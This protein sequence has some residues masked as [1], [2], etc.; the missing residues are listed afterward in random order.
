MSDSINNLLEDLQDYMFSDKNIEKYTKNNIYK[1]PVSV[2]P[3]RQSPVKILKRLDYFQ[4][5]H[6][7]SL[8]WC[9]YILK[10]GFGKYD[11]LGNQ[12]FVEEKKI[13]FSYVDLVRLNK[14]LLKMNKIKPLSEIEDDLANKQQI[15]L[16]TF[17]AICMIMEIN[18][19]VVDKHKYYEFIRDDSKIIN[20]IYKT[21]KP[22]KYSLD[23][24]SSQEKIDNYRKNYFKMPTLDSNLK[25]ITSYKM[26]DLF[27]MCEKLGIEVHNSNKKRTKKDLY[28]LIV[29][30]F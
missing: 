14:P 4:P 26:E 18:V 2:K 20:I 17:I 11:M 9:L 13:K 8:F 25:S 1:S 15:G 12:H 5:N 28:E 6:I 21:E 3:I 7:D 30:N 24:N 16:K 10:D 19:L 23:L 29:I 22:L 27:N